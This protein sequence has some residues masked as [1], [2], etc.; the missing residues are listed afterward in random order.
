M[1]K[2]H[3]NIIL[4]SNSPRRKDIL[5]GLSIPFSVYVKNNIDEY[6]P[7]SVSDLDVP[8]YLSKKKAEA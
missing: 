1:E 7:A 8:L 3:Y 4:A 6:Y 5:S 2:K